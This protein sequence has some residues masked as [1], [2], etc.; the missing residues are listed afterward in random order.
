MQSTAA[1]LLSWSYLTSRQPLTPSITRS[2]W[3]GCELLVAWTVQL[4]HGSDVTSSDAD[5]MFAAGAIIHLPPT[6]SAA[7]HKDQSSDLSYSSSIQLTWHRSSLHQYA[8]DS[9]IYGSCPPAASYTL[10][11]AEC[12]SKIAVSNNIRFMRIFAGIRWTGGVK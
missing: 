6:S 1:R 12:R 9:H 4:S 5:S 11:A 10:S 7:Y 8:D 3:K 2:S